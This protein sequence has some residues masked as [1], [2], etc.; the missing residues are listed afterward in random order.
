MKN[1]KKIL[2]TVVAAMLLV[3]MSV[4]GTLAYLTST[5]ETVTNTF[6]VGNVTITLDEA[7]VKGDGTQYNTTHEERVIIN[8]YKLQPGLTYLKDPTVTVKANSE[9]AYVRILVDV[10]N[11]SSLKTAFPDAKDWGEGDVFLLQNFVNGWNPANWEYKKCTVKDN[12]ATY[13]FWYT[14]IVP[15]STQDQKLDDLFESITMPDDMTNTELA[16][17]AGLQI[18]VVAHAIQAEGFVTEN[19]K[20]AMENAWATWDNG[21]T[22]MPAATATPVPTAEPTT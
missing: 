1:M 2:L 3:V 20:T 8:N 14:A 10:T 19:D 13:E 9:A 5:T 15:A 18:N 7:K 12:V 6:S 22:L 11:Y 21:I 4:A 17:L 16:A